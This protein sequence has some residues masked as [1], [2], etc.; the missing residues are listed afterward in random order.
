MTGADF[1]GNSVAVTG[2]ASGIGR[3]V[4]ARFAAAGASVLMI[5]A[6]EAALRDAASRIDGASTAVVDVTDAARVE[7]VLGSADLPLDVVIANAGIGAPRAPI[8]AI[9]GE[10]WHRVI[11]VNL[12]GV[13]NTFRAASCRM[14]ESGRGGVLLATASISGL[15]PEPG[16]TAYTAS[17][18]GVVG[19]VRAAAVELAPHGIRINAV[20]PGDV[21]TPMLAVFEGE[22]A[23]AEVSNDIPLGRPARPDEIAALYLFLAGPDATYM[24]G[25]T[26]VIDGG[27]SSTT[28]AG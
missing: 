25:S 28:L 1:T 14:V 6:D 18:F 7:E 4:A 15:V 23:A 9:G 11:A 27:L 26:V 5:D 13:F 22:G 10:Q 20:C 8:F 24:T 17:K 16:A 19:L 12:T 21:D 3:A 2:A